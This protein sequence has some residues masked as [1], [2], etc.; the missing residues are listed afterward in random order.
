MTRGVAGTYDAAAGG[1]AERAVR[2]DGV[3]TPKRR[4]QRHAARVDVLGRVAGARVRHRQVESQTQLGR[5]V[6]SLAQRYPRRA[7]RRGGGGGGHR[8]RRT[9]RRRGRARR[10]GP[11]ARRRGR[12]GVP[13]VR[14]PDSRVGPGRGRGGVGCRGG[15]TAGG[16][17]A[18][19]GAQRG[20]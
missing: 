18:L 11:A 4:R 3:S 2:H 1:D 19:I 16:R 10:G 15:R 17:A 9:C 12:A 14:Y 5:R 20:G 6:A 13:P 8:R 7:V